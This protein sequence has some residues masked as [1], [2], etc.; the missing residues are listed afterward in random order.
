MHS[1]LRMEVE[2]DELRREKDAWERRCRYQRQTL[3][4]LEHQLK[5]VAPYDT[6]VRSIKSSRYVTTYFATKAE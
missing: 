6:R 5:Q 4:L 2:L 3:G 1:Y